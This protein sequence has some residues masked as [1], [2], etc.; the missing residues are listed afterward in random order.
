MF[1]IQIIKSN[2]KSEPVCFLYKISTKNDYKL[3]INSDGK[4]EAKQ[5]LKEK[6]E[7]KTNVKDYFILCKLTFHTGTKHGQGGPIA[8][9]FSVYTIEDG[10]V[11]NIIKSNDDNLTKLGNN[12]IGTIWFT[13]KFLEE[14]NWNKNYLNNIIEKLITNKAKITKLVVNKYHM[15]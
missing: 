11:K 6:Y 2:I 14:K 8:A 1:D 15:L 3:I 13:K 9:N 7:K 4:N 12:M 10:I 5:L